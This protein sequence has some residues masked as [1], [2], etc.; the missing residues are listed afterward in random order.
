MAFWKNRKVLV[1]GAGGFVGSWLAEALQAKGAEVYVILEEGK[2]A[3][4][5]NILGL[6]RKVNAAKGDI[7]DFKL[8]RKILNKEIE[9]VY[10]LAAQSIVTK[11]NASPVRTFDVNMRGAWNVLEACRINRSGLKAVVVASSDKAYGAHKKLP[12]KEESPL[13]PR[14][15]YDASKACEDLIARSYFYTF[16]L[17][18]AVTRCSNIYGGGDFNFSRIIPDAMRSV[19][20][21]KDPVIRSDGTPL[22]DYVYIDDIVAFYLLL[23]ERMAARGVAGEAFNAGTG[24]PVTVLELVKKIIRISG[25][26]HLTPAIKGKSNPH[27]EIPHQYLDSSKAGRVLGWKAEVNLEEGLRET[28]KWYER[29]KD[30]LGNG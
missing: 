3:P 26:K 4:N 1:T 22:R 12:Y 27:A 13:L 8:L 25:K 6:G 9:V 19:V 17:P 21:G 29:H 23:G 11:A 5:F 16:G 10:H 28:Y 14:Y 18:V 2:D 15:P 24:K 30:L 20:C 7:T